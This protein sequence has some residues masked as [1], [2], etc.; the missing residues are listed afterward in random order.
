MA[1]VTQRERKITLAINVSKADELPQTADHIRDFLDALDAANEYD[2][3]LH[4]GVSTPQ[5]D[6]RQP[7]GF[8][9]HAVGPTVE[10]ELDEDDEEE[11][12]GLEY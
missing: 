9:A 3:D 6:D 11:P 7:I 1:Q 8:G 12:D 4:V 10:I 2:V 5:E